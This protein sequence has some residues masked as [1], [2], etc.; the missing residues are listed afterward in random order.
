[1]WSTCNLD[2]N[3]LVNAHI[4]N[5]A[6]H[7]NYFT[8]KLCKFHHIERYANFRD[9]KKRSVTLPFYAKIFNFKDI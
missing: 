4:C 3:H 6:S 2:P 5:N 9:H 7:K 8:A 1:M